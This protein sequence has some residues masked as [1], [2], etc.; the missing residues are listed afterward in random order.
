[1]SRTRGVVQNRPKPFVINLLSIISTSDRKT[2]KIKITVSSKI[3]TNSSGT[4]DHIRAR[5]YLE[6]KL[7]DLLKVV[8]CRMFPVFAEL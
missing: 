3:K 6:K 7:Q 5:M 8:K 2:T 4:S 1:M